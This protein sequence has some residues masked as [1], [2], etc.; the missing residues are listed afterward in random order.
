MIRHL[1]DVSRIGFVKQ[2]CTSRAG[3]AA[4]RYGE[5]APVTTA[6]CNACRTC[7]TTNVVALALAAVGG[8]GVAATR[9][10]QRLARPA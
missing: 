3:Q 7:V 4:V 1:D 6:C 10:V 2:F 5:H 9:F 8:A